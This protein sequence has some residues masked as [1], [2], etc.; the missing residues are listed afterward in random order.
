MPSTLLPPCSAKS[1]PWYISLLL[2]L[3]RHWSKSDGRI[4]L[5]I[6]AHFQEG[7]SFASPSYSSRQLFHPPL[8]ISPAPAKTYHFHFWENRNTRRSRG[9]S[10]IPDSPPALVLSFRHEDLAVLLTMANPFPGALDQ[11]SYP[12]LKNI[13]LATHF[14]LLPSLIFPGLDHSERVIYFSNPFLNCY[15]NPIK[16]V[17]F[18]PFYKWEKLL[19]GEFQLITVNGMKEFKN[20]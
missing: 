1:Q 17:W 7:P 2:T 4:S 14:L 11:I 5:W 8:Q 20:N 9:T 13:I 19:T 12:L 15:N 16:Q 18:S 3:H 6:Q 10:S